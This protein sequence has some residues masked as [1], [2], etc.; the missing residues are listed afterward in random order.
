MFQAVFRC[1]FA[2]IEVR[3]PLDARVALAVSGVWFMGMRSDCV[4]TLKLCRDAALI[5]ARD[6]GMRAACLSM[7]FFCLL[8]FCF[9]NV[10][11]LDLFIVELA[12]CGMPLEC[13]KRFAVFQ[14]S[15][16]TA[17]KRSVA[18]TPKS[19]NS[20]VW[21][22]LFLRRLSHPGRP[23]MCKVKRLGKLTLLQNLPF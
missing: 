4:C 22:L 14:T 8:F 17:L 7:L 1:M 10:S 20:D 19:A 6:F 3:V 12:R 11:A 18:V 23:A 9:T 5:C 13:A 2:L 16:I 15:T 21:F